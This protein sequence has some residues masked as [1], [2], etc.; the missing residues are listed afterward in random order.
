MSAPSKPLAT[1]LSPA[2]LQQSAKPPRHRR[3]AMR[4][5]PASAPPSTAP[6]GARNG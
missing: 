5:M 1:L 3:S 4:L 2:R 6:P